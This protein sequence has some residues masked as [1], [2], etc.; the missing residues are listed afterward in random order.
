[1]LGTPKYEKTVQVL[2]H[3]I[4]HMDVISTDH[5]GSLFSGKAEVSK[6]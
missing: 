6:A 4:T 3:A 5:D 2:S 1:M